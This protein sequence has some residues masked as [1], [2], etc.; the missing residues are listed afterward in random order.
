MQLDISNCS[1][2]ITEDLQ[3]AVIYLARY[4]CIITDEEVKSSKK[5]RKPLY[6]TIVPYGTKTKSQTSPQNWERSIMWKSVNCLVQYFSG[7]LDIHLITTSLFCTEMTE[8]SFYV[9]SADKN[10]I[11]LENNLVNSSRIMDYIWH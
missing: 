9:I 1:P 10:L 8:L 5:P 11:A 7:G 6:V 2:S 4:Y 3:V